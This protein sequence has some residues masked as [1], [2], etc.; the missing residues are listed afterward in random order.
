MSA[1][2]PDEYSFT[3]LEQKSEGKAPKGLKPNTRLRRLVFVYEF[4]REYLRRQREC[5]AK[6][7]EESLGGGDPE[8][9]SAVNRVL[10]LEENATEISDLAHDL[11][12]YL[13]KGVDI[14]GQPLP[15]T[16]LVKRRPLVPEI[17]FVETPFLA[18]PPAKQM[19]VLDE[20]GA[21]VEAALVGVSHLH[22]YAAFLKPSNPDMV[23]KHPDVER[24][25]SERRSRFMQEFLKEE[26]PDEGWLFAK[27]DF[28][29]TEEQAARRFLDARRRAMQKLNRLPPAAKTEIVA[30][31]QKGVGEGKGNYV[32]LLTAL[33]AVRA[34]RHYG[35]WETAFAQTQSRD[36]KTRRKTP[37]LSWEKRKW[38]GAHE[39]VNRELRTLYGYDFQ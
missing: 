9:R 16:K 37:L 25:F 2:S 17:N 4:A 20:F 23:A 30:Q 27:L 39:I 28:K 13:A 7:F 14:E 10:G 5:Q 29:E 6:I 33:G 11:D 26:S 3:W 36:P 8:S 12:V 38:E 24:R 32:R 15:E 22:N 21:D 35:D 18:L 1:L 34:I 31:G 19:D